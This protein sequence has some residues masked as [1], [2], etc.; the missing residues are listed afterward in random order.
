MNLTLDEVVYAYCI[1][2]EQDLTQENLDKAYKKLQDA[3]NKIIKGEV[4]I[5]S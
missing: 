1:M 5:E 4:K 3:L 2:M